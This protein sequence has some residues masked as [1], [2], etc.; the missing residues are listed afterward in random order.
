MEFKYEGIYC[1]YE[2]LKEERLLFELYKGVLT[3]P[4]MK[5]YIETLVQEPDYNNN[6]DLL[7]DISQVTYDATTQEVAEFA[8]YLIAQGHTIGIRKTAV[9]YKTPNQHVYAYI[10]MQLYKDI[11]HLIKLFTD[12]NEAIEWL[13]PN[14]D[15]AGNIA[16][17]TELQNKSKHSD[18][19]SL[20][21]RLIHIEH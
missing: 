14:H 8:R 9:L 1:G 4:A 2:I 13:R 12:K 17:L 10:Y 19:H 16:K 11:P 7:T 3:L 6:F 15:N 21:K 20:L 18:A 5:K